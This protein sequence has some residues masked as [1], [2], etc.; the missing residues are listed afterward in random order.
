MKR[1]ALALCVAAVAAQAL[2]AQETPATPTRRRVAALDFDYATVQNS[3]ARL[4]GSDVNI[5]KG[6]HILVESELAQNGT[7]TVIERAQVDR[8][9]NE[10][11]F[12]QNWRADASS[13][14]KLGK[15]LG[16][17]AVVIGAVTQFERENNTI[18]FGLKKESKATVVIN[19]RVV[20]IKTGASRVGVST[21]LTL[22]SLT[23]GVSPFLS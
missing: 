15:L 19:A 7:Y 22:K 4:M 6:I 10:Q 12:Q 2:D 1:L 14:A 9:L 20:G 11:N 21:S 13:A 18:A 5:G 8:I 23:W 17:D 3:V 16:T